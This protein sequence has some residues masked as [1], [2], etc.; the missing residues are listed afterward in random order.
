LSGLSFEKV[1]D[2]IS[3]ELEDSLVFAGALDNNAKLLSFRKGSGKMALPVERH[4]TLDVQISLLFSL[5]HQLED[6]AGSHRFTLTRFGK[7]NIFLFGT[8]DIHLF[9]VSS[10][11]SDENNTSRVMSEIVT[12]TL[13]ETPAVAVPRR[14]PTM[15]STSHSPFA[16]QSTAPDSP[17]LEKS[18]THSQMT[19]R[20]LK[21]DAIVM[22]Q[23]YLMGTD[24]GLAIDEDAEGF[25]IRSTSD[26]GGKVPW[27]IVE[28]INT[29]FGGKIEITA[30]DTD[31][32]GRLV[33]R[34]IAR[35]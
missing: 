9:I 10:P 17:R 29:T 26:R 35:E 25:T 22:L 8:P 24:S 4:E 6:I 2:K 33:I 23:G 1:L 31:Q 20:K 11:G 3:T 13:G 21:P 32:D 30:I 5:L 12:M 16:R 18:Q 27:S 28:R 19:A 7:Y 15:T 34:I 14:E